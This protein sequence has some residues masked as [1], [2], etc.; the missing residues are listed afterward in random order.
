MQLSVAIITGFYMLKM[1]PPHDL[2]PPP[3]PP[4]NV[5][6]KGKNFIMLEKHVCIFCPPTLPPQVRSEL[7]QFRKNAFKLV[8]Y[9]VT[10]CKIMLFYLYSVGLKVCGDIFVATRWHYMDILGVN[11]DR[12]DSSNRT[13]M[14]AMSE[15][16]VSV[17]NVVD[18][19]V[20]DLVCYAVNPTKIHLVRAE[21]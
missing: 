11:H 1:T 5:V 21:S 9:I 20:Y 4:Y 10:Q 18:D 15:D 16:I 2:S 13:Y 19:N 3:Y 17:L 12:R 8:L 7:L 6:P 14:T